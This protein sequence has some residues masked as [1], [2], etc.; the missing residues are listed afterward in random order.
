APDEPVSLPAPRPLSGDV[1]GEAEK[2]FKEWLGHQ[3]V[4]PAMAAVITLWAHAACAARDG[5]RDEVQRISC[6]LVD[7]LHRHDQRYVE[8]PAPLAAPGEE[9]TPSYHDLDPHLRRVASAAIR[10]CAKADQEITP[11]IPHAPGLRTAHNA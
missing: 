8:M 1:L 11:T 3:D 9:R 4:R 7:Q 2:L 10:W 5:S 6:F